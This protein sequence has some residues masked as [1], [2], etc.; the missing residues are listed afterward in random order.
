MSDLASVFSLNKFSCVIC[1]GSSPCYGC[2]IKTLNKV[3]HYYKGFY[4]MV[5]SI[6]NENLNLKS[7]QISDI[8]GSFVVSD[9]PIPLDGW[10]FDL[11]LWRFITLTFDPQKF[12][13]SNDPESE[14]NY[15]LNIILA[16]ARLSYL[17]SVYGSFELHKNGTVH[18][19]LIAK[20][21][22]QDLY[23]FLKKKLTDNPKNRNAVDEGPA[24]FPNCI[25]YIE[26]ESKNYYKLDM[27]I[28]VED[29]QNPLDIIAE[30]TA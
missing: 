11:K 15:M 12:G 29:Q 10:N 1:Y 26:K 27:P 24:R 5:N 28:E 22:S 16:A 20:V 19:H 7:Y 18:T 8:F 30:N 13:C 25:Q 17:S 4:D 21:H 6:Q 23:Y 14:R 2:Q 9:S 3:V